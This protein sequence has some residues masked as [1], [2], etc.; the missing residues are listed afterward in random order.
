MMMVVACIWYSSMDVKY[1]ANTEN[2]HEHE[3]RFVHSTQILELS[4]NIR[5]LGRG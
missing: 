5:N 3:V 2:V 1:Y 4:E